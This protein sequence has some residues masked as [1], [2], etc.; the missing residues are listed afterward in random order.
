MW[1]RTTVISQ[2]HPFARRS[3]AA[4]LATLLATGASGCLGQLDF[5]DDTG[6]ERDTGVFPFD[7]GDAADASDNPSLDVGPGDSGDASGDGGEPDVPPPDPVLGDVV[8]GVFAPACTPCH[9][10]RVSGGLSLLDRPGL[11]DTLLAPSVQAPTIA[12]VV[13]GDTE[14]SYLWLKLV[15]RHEEA[16]GIGERMPLSGSLTAAQLDLVERWIAAGA[17]P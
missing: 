3:P 9:T 4:L 2:T 8:R 1:Y 16:G 13:P 11:H 5:P 15:D 7:A 17:L 10:D 14:A 6:R 12:R